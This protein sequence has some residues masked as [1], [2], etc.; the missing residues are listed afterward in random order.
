MRKW[1]ILGALN[2]L[3]A[4]L[5]GAFATH[6]LKDTVP[7]YELGIFEMAAQYQ[8]YHALAFIAVA[9]SIGQ[10]GDMRVRFFA[11]LSGWAFLVGII[12]FS[13]SLYHMGMT[14]SRA[15]V[16]VTP[17]GGTAFLVGWVALL[18]AAWNIKG[19]KQP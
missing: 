10:S 14:Q 15:L 16:I 6:G 2:G 4:V 11:D 8:M 1:A 3:I 12:L 17:L 19:E 9:W 5:A 18:A 13:G 7:A